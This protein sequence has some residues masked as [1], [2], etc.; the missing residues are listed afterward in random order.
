MQ[1]RAGALDELMASGALE[2]A[3]GTGKDSITV[4][5]ERMASE[6]DVNDQM[7]ALKR[8]LG[9]STAA[10]QS[11]AAPAAEQLAASPAMPEI[12]SPAKPEIEG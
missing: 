5:L 8:E 10:P 2:D 9:T 1:A 3:T 11:I 12:T 7:E 4:E 6:T